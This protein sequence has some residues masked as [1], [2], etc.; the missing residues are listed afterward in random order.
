MDNYDVLNNKEKFYSKTTGEVML[1]LLNKTFEIPDTFQAGLA[2]VEEEYIAR[3]DL[4][5]L[6]L[7]GDDIYADIICKLNG[8]SNPFELNA[9]MTLLLPS[10]DSLKDF[11]IKS[12]QKWAESELVNPTVSAP[13]PKHTNQ[14][15]QPNEAVIGDSRFNI[16]RTSQ[17]V[18]Y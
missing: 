18:V 7:Y 4:V 5:S 1:D 9:G 3:P 15:R 16:D 12:S 10:F 17:I 2:I 8:I 6:A 14:P 13:Q 11:T